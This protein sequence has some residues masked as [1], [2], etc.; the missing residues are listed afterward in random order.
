MHGI[1]MAYIITNPDNE[2]SIKS[3]LFAGA[4]FE[5]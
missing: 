5:R 4:V 1:E 3:A 2:A